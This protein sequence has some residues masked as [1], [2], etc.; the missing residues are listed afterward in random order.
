[1]IDL[2]EPALELAFERLEDGGPMMPFALVTGADGGVHC[3]S[4][5]TNRSDE[6]A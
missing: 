2:I 5:V 4:I 3:V 1:M 6:A